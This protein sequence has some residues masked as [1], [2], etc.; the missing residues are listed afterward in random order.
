M[1]G[2]LCTVYG[3]QV[4]LMQGNDNQNRGGVTAKKSVISMEW[5]WPLKWP[6]S[7]I[8]VHY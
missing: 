7:Q 4:Y 1:T 3:A 2:V 8:P 6:C 5:Q